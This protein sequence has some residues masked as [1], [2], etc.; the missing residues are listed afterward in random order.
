MYGKFFDFF[1]QSNMINGKFFDLSHLFF[2]K[3]SLI[4]VGLKV[5]AKETAD[6]TKM[7]MK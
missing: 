6:R 3:E 7:K 2:V 1:S 4:Y 5:L